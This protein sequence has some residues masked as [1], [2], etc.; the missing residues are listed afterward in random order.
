[1]DGQEDKQDM[2]RCK[3]IILQIL[4]IHVKKKKEGV[5]E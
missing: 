2:K 5:T 1:M 4:S 3:E